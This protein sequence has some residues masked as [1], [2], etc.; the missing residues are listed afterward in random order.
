MIAGVATNIMLLQPVQTPGNAARL[1]LERRQ[2]LA[3]DQSS[4]DLRPEQTALD[5]LIKRAAAA[6]MSGAADATNGLPRAAG[7]RMQT[8][9]A[10]I[11]M[12]QGPRRFARLRTDAAQAG[13]TDK[14]PEA[15]DAEGDPEVIKAVQRELTTQGYGPLTPDG[16]PG[17][18][19]RAA[20]MAFEHDSR[21]PLTGEATGRLLGRLQMTP[22]LAASQP[23]DPAAG[24]VRS[25]A[26]ELVIRTVQQSLAALGYQVGRVD[27]RPG[28]DVQRAI[29]EFELDEGLA[30]TGRVSAEVFARL[31]RVVAAAKPKTA[32]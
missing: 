6:S 12:E 7:G 30:P 15:P 4:T 22:A 18:V 21:M 20:I 14:L 17:L 32:Q 27:G 10:Q 19:T 11:Q 31:G 23:P 25:T 13:A 9:S 28:D 29:Q 16:V 8:T 24:K 3:L 1:E 26:A 2:R 5:N